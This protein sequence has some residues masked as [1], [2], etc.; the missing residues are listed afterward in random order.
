MDLTQMLL[1]GAGGGEVPRGES[2]YAIPGTYTWVCP[3]GVT[4]VSAVVVGAGGSGEFG[5]GGGALAYRNNITVTPGVSYTV[6]VGAVAN[7]NTN[8]TGGT[9]SFYGDSKIG[10]AHV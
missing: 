4:S 10:R 7:G 9:S 8:T 3:A 2:V 6:I 1:M 5:G